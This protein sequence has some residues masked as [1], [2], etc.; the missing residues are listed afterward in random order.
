MTITFIP[1]PLL[2]A[3]QRQLCDAIERLTAARGFAPSAREL[4]A[5]MRVSLARVGQLIAST[6]AKGALVR[7]PGVARSLRLTPA[8]AAPKR[9]R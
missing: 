5:D 8:A 6:A 9:G 1:A 2:S 7:E 3:R 4:A